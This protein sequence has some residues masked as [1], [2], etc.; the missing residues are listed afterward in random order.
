[1]VDWPASSL[2]GCNLPARTGKE[3]AVTGICGMPS[4]IRFVVI[5]LVLAGIGFGAMVGLIAYVEPKPKE[6]QV[7]VPSD[8]LELQ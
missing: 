1:M 7:R 5:L 3:K 6:V 8:K 2:P 4:L